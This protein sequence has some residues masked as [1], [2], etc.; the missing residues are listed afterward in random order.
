MVNFS[1]R[2]PWPV[3]LAALVFYGV[4]SSHG[5]T[6]SGLALTAKI[7]GWDSVPMVGQPLLWLLTV[8]FR[9]WPEAWVPLGLNW[10]CALTAALTLGVLARSVQLLPW[11]QPW[12]NARS[13][14][15]PVLLAVVVC[16]LEFNFWQQATN[17]SGEML[18]VLLLAAALWLLLEY[19]VRQ[20]PR[21]PGNFTGKPVPQTFKSAASRVSKPADAS[22]SKRPAGIEIGEPKP[23]LPSAGW[24]TSVAP[25]LPA[26]ANT[27]LKYSGWLWAAALVWG[28]GIAENWV[29]LLTLPLFVAGVVWLCGWRCL[30]LEFWLRLAVPGLAGFSIYALL[31]LVNGLWPHS[32]W[33]L[34]QAWRVSWQQTEN[35]VRQLGLEFWRSHRLLALVVVIYYLA[36]TLSFLVRVRDMS[37]ANKSGLDRF[38]VWIYHAFRVVL[39]LACLW[40]AFDPLIGLRQI[41]L[42]QLGASLP[43]L[44]FDYLNALGAAFLAGN[45]LLISQGAVESRQWPPSKINWRA[46][47]VPFATVGL[48]LMIA[49]LAARN[50]PAMLRMNFH[51]LQRF[52]ELSADSLPGEGGVVVSGEAEKLA[53]F[54]AA[55]AHRPRAAAW[56]AVD[57]RRLPSVAYRAGLERRHPW[58]WLTEASRHELNALEMLQMLAGIAGHQRLFYLNPSFG[59]LF[60]QFYLEPAGSVWEMKLRGKTLLDYPP[61]SRAA[62]DANEKFWSRAWEK[63]LSA[64]ALVP[65]ERRTGWESIEKRL[66]VTPAP[67]FQDRLLAQWFS[68]SLD[69]WGVALQKQGRWRDAQTRLEQALQLNPHN[70]SARISLA[71]NT[72]LQSGRTLGLADLGQVAGQVGNFDR[73][74]LV[75]NQDGPFDDPIFCYLLGCAFQ[76]S[77]LW[78]QAVEQFER[79]RQLAPGVQAP[80]FALSELYPRLRMSDRAQP[81]INHLR[82]AA[83]YGQ[84]SSALDLELAMLE[85]NSWL[86][87]TN[88]A[89][90]R[91][92][93]KTLLKQH[94]G[95]VQI[96]N[97]AMLAYLSMHDFKSA[98]EL[99]DA[100]LSQAPDEV[101]S[102][103]TKAVMLFQSGNAAAALPVLDRIL[104]LTNLPEARIE[105]AMAYAATTNYAAAKADYLELQHVLANPFAA[106]SG[107]AQL[108]ELQHDTNQAIH[109]LELCLSNAPP[110]SV[111]WRQVRARLLSLQKAP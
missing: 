94:P 78:V 70:F 69:S 42:K 40:L 2:L 46:R 34:G 63:D 30:S 3:T 102:L 100:K 52:G 103:N 41:L 74:G 105:R 1:R 29:M 84:S 39:L 54:Q 76:R 71:C 55:L 33:S 60:E 72:N 95:D 81:L 9:L 12:E 15:L 65:G 57:L 111:Q 108:A 43:L 58:G 18:D 8:P 83:N 86:A 44:T 67:V 73:L 92:A 14:A 50:A 5:L 66:G 62:T 37:T 20:E 21:W 91:S 61:P 79:T 107:L 28:I 24:E 59:F 97:R 22:Y 19:R 109:Y 82:E 36:P 38:Q 104:T 96:A 48:G 98:L 17:A 87:Q 51:A 16:G 89:N 25:V 80:E 32:P 106:E 56:A 13:S 26:S 10:F 110:G 88:L 7:A 31:P 53:V 23:G 101:S 45:L 99:I 6:M 27:A 35:T 85:V 49:G 68:I 77:D 11:D 90:A 4:T 64:L 93:V 47:A 75:I